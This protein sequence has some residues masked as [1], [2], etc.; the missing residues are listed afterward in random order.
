MGVELLPG[1]RV[2]DLEYADDIALLG[3]N[4]Q[5]MQSALDRLAIEASRYGMCFAPEKCKV[6]LQDWREPVPDLYQNGE[7]M[8]VVDTFNYLGSCITAGGGV[9]EEISLRIAKA[10]LAF[11]NLRH[12]WRRRDISLSIKGRV[13]CAA[14]RSVLLYGC[15]TWPLLAKDVHRLAVFDNRCLR[16]IARVWWQQRIRNDVVQRRVLGPSNL[17]LSQ[18]ISLHQL[19]WLGHVLRMPVQRLPYRAL[20]AV[21]GH[22]WKKQAGGQTMTWRR[23]V[24]KLTSSLA[25]IGRSRLPGW[26]PRDAECCWLETLRDMAKDRHQWRECIYFC[27]TGQTHN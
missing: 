17:P 22:D 3:D 10:R 20:F 19:R 18:L 11:A 25:S 15:E 12:L 2:G 21:P 9:G 4:S 23:G 16:R 7:R 24:K 1:N 14:V 13:Y 26:G 27:S 6:L 8:E 5:V